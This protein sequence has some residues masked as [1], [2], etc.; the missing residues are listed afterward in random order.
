MSPLPHRF[1]LGIYMPPYG[2][3]NENGE[4][5]FCVEKALQAIGVTSATTHVEVIVTGEGPRV[6][7]IAARPGG[8]RIPTDLI[9]LVYGMD[10]MADSIRIALGHKPIEKRHYERGTALYWFPAEPG[11]VEEID[12]RE[13]AAKL[14][15]VREIDFT[16]TVGERLDPI[17]DC[18]T[19]DKVGYVFTEGDTAADAVRAAREALR[20]C[21]VRTRP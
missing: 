8:G 20:L 11:L 6:V 2:P 5:E 3:G 4:I 17:V 15:G 12:G 21:A 14:K 9:P 19:R 1:D 13:E 16:A 7:E 18:V 10:F